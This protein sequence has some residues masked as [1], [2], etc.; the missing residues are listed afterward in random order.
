MKGFRPLN[1][2][3]LAADYLQTSLI[4]SIF[5]I[6]QV[7][8]TVKFIRKITHEKKAISMDSS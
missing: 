3:K 6:C 1:C 5:Q 4:L 2:R 8:D 7:A